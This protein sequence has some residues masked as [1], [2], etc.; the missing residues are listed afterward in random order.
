MKPPWAGGGGG[1]RDYYGNLE[2]A[3]SVVYCLCGFFWVPSVTD[4]SK[5]LDN[6]NNNR[7]IILDLTYLKINLIFL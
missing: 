1:G 3:Q 5:P 7:I 6:N 2:E 4:N